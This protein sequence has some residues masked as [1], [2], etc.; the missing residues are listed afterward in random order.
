MYIIVLERLVDNLA[1]A[2]LTSYIYLNVIIKKINVSL[3][4]SHLF[5]Y[6]INVPV[7]IVYKKFSLFN[8]SPTPDNFWVRG[9]NLNNFGILHLDYVIDR[10]WK[11]YTFWAKIRGFK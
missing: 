8:F 6:R 10:I 1:F 11:R 7:I 2:G 9:Y 4:F 5:F 3:F